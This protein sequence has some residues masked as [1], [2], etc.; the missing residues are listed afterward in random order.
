M[1]S[2]QRYPKS[3]AQR[4]FSLAEHHAKGTNITSQLMQAVAADDVQQ[5]KRYPLMCQ[6]LQAVKAGILQS[7]VSKHKTQNTSQYPHPSRVSTPVLRNLGS[8][9]T[10]PVACKDKLS[11]PR[12]LFNSI[13]SC[14][15]P[16]VASPQ[17]AVPPTNPRAYHHHAPVS[18]P[19]V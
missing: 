13:R 5:N 1:P 12:R 15:A 6:P 11:S 4:D 17:V 3:M 19:P 10:H 9:L 2:S 16:D 14:W 8:I 18:T 7:Q